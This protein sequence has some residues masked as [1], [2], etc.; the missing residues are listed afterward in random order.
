MIP[1]ALHI[2]WVE[3]FGT[4]DYQDF[5]LTGREY[6]DLFAVG[7]DR[8]RVPLLKPFDPDT[9]GCRAFHCFLCIGLGRAEEGDRTLNEPRLYNVV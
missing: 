7:V 4:F 5:F 9:L 8:H 6:P 3:P 1:D 2:L